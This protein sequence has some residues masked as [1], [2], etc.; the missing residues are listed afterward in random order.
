MYVSLFVVVVAIEGFVKTFQNWDG[1]PNSCRR[2]SHRR[3]RQKIPRLEEQRQQCGLNFVV[4][5]DDADAAPHHWRLRTQ[6]AL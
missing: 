2:C 3:F 4:G 5:P 6:M 1:R